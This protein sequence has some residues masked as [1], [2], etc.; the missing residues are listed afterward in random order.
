MFSALLTFQISQ[1]QIDLALS[2]PDYVH[3]SDTYPPRILLTVSPGP[4]TVR[5][6]P[7]DNFC[8]IG[9]NGIIEEDLGKFTLRFPLHPSSDP[10][11]VPPD[12]PKGKCIH[13]YQILD[14]CITVYILRIIIATDVVQH[15]MPTNS[16]IFK[17]SNL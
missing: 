11:H 9:V 8:S 4:V 15:T 12:H 3:L 6:K 14:L 5:V 16:G 17:T 1:E 2:N 7:P 13:G 10:V